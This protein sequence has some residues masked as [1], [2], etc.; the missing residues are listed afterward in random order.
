MLR[1]LDQRIRSVDRVV[2]QFV[3]LSVGRDRYYTWRELGEITLL[4]KNVIMNIG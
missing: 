2:N 1:C 4:D 3:R